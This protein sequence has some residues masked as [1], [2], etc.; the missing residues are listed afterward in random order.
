MAPGVGDRHED[1]PQIQAGLPAQS[2]QFEA[3]RVIC[4]LRSTA[5]GAVASRLHTA[6]DAVSFALKA[7]NA[8][9]A[10]RQASLR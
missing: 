4:T 10:S 2:H 7:P 6:H 5:N 1:C 9:H 8:R 3:R